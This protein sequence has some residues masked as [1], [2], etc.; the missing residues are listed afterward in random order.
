MK[1]LLC[2]LVIGFSFLSAPPRLLAQDDSCFAIHVRL[3][4][5][6]VDGPETVTLRTAENESATSLEAGCFKVPPAVFDEK[7]VDVVFTVPGNRVY[8]PAVSTGFL[9]GPWDVE[10]E[11]RRFGK[12]VVLP[13]H[14]QIKEACV[15]IFHVGDPET[16]VVVSRCRTPL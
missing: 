12:E 1:T 8:L 6:V 4:G 15:V 11:D 16:A 7:R 9:V 2:A 5:G 3:N 13:K 14:T 10:L